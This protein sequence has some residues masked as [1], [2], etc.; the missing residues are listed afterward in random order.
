MPPATPA[1]HALF[2]AEL[3]QAEHFAGLLATTGIA[4]GHLGPRE[5]GRIWDRH[6]TNSAVVTDLVPVGATVLDVGSGAGLPG[7]AMA[8]RRPDLELVLIEPMLRRSTF[9]EHVV[10]EVGLAERVRVLRGRA[11]DPAVRVAAGG[12]SW[13]TARAVAPL[14]RLVSWCLPLLVAGGQLLALKGSSA[15][16]EVA[17]FETT[18]PRPLRTAVAGLTVIELGQD[19]AMDTTQVIRVE[20]SARIEAR[21]RRSQ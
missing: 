12:A 7:V 13:V 18:A 21:R 4:H 16:D 5:V 9:L 14:E 11:E 15:S 6:L 20:R 19:Y 3:P 2:G 10:A 1:A 17:R 8:I